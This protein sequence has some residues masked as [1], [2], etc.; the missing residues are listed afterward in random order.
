MIV[1]AIAI[2]QPLGI[3]L[4]MSDNVKNKLCVHVGMCKCFSEAELLWKQII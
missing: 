4:L 1:A 2:F 3:K